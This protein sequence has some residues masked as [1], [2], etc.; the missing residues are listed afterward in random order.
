[1]AAA[2]LS[3]DVRVTADPEHTCPLVPLSED[4]ATLHLVE[5]LRTAGGAH[6]IVNRLAHRGLAIG[7][8]P[9]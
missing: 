9:I 5:I 6:Q 2:D 4:E 7:R 3:I 1:M 8:K